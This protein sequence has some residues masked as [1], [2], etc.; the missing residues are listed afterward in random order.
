M[1][2]S[3]IKFEVDSFQQIK[4]FDTVIW[5]K[6]RSNSGVCLFNFKLLESGVSNQFFGI[7]CAKLTR[8]K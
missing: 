5:E 6:N 3:Q 8:K 1:T 7:F 4:K 2:W